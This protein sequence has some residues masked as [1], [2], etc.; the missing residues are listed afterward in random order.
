MP[1]NVYLVG[2]GAVGKE[3]VR[4]CQLKGW[5]V[6]C[7]ETSKGKHVLEPDGRLRKINASGLADYD[8]TKIS[9]AFL[10]IPASEKGCMS[11]KYAVYFAQRD[12]PVVCCE[13][14]LFAYHP[15]YLDSFGYSA[16]AGAMTSRY[17]LT[18]MRHSTSSWKVMSPLKTQ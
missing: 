13:K 11:K 9:L 2:Y 3:V 6:T 16:T 4:Q 14:S 1:T 17:T 15:Y 18:S 8:H 12:V 10:A 5:N 7:V